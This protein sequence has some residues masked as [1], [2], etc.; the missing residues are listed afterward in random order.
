MSHLP[1]NEDKPQITGFAATSSGTLAVLTATGLSAL[2]TVV[3]AR[4]LSLNGRGTLVAAYTCINLCV[5]AGGLSLDSSAMYFL[6]KHAANQLGVARRLQEIAFLGA[7]ITVLGGSAVVV[8][9]THGRLPFKAVILMCVLSSTQ[10]MG[11]VVL[12]QLRISGHLHAS[13]WW[14]SSMLASGQTAGIVAMLITR[15]VSDILIVMSFGS[16]LPWFW[17]VWRNFQGKVGRITAPVTPLESRREMVGY[18]LKAHPGAVIYALF[19]RVPLLALSLVSTAAAV[20]ILSIGTSIAELGLVVSQ[21]MLSWV[22]SAAGNEPHNYSILR[23]ALWVDLTITVLLSALL[24]S[25]SIF[26]VPIILGQAY[27]VSGV[28]V[29]VL[30]PGVVVLALWRIAAYDLA[31]RGYP[32]PRTVS[33]VLGVASSIPLSLLLSIG[34]GCTGAAV[35]YSLG[36]FVL[37]GTLFYYPGHAQRM[38]RT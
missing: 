32:W 23:R 34:F 16:M 27:H 30:A 25:G 37:G 18:A 7:L 4:V 31:V 1:R 12:A 26:A 6:G 17:I 8:V 5:V 19:S 33:A 24:A 28:L 36:A 15:S 21:G 2:N 10:V 13:A 38:L 9:F 20:S 22:L 11:G 14:S 35:A 3:S 29:V